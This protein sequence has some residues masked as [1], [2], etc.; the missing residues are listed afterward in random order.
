[1]RD[2][3]LDIGFRLEAHIQSQ[4]LILFLE[5]E[6]NEKLSLHT[7]PSFSLFAFYRLVD[8][9]D[10]KVVIKIFHIIERRY[11]CSLN[12]CVVGVFDY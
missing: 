12:A 5:S 8:I 4:K 3:Y 11:G 7:S 2:K 9:Y 10:E 1:M 6:K